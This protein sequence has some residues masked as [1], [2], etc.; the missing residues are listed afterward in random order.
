[1]KTDNPGNRDYRFDVQLAEGVAAEGWFYELTRGGDR[2]EVKHDMRAL[3][4]GNLFVEI[5]NDPGR[6][7][8]WKASGIETTEA[9]CWIFVL[10]CPPNLFLGIPTEHLR[11]LLVDARYVNQPYGSCPTRGALISLRQLLAADASQVAA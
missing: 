5:A 11:E 3:E 4:T 7:G 1:M 6:R 10:G 2:F 9:D 8:V